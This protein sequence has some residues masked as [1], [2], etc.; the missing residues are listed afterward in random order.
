MVLTALKETEQALTGYAAEIDHHAALTAARDRAK[1]AF[2]L[3]QVQYR[4]GTISLLDLLTAQTTLLGAQQALAA[5]DQALSNDQIAVFQALGGG[6]EGAP[7]V[8]PPKIAG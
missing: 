8:R 1:E 5:S 6:W 2:D 3:A 4:T 7:A